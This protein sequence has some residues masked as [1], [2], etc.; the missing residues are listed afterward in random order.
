MQIKGKGLMVTYWLLGE[1]MYKMETNK[2]AGDQFTGHCGRSTKR[3]LHALECLVFN[4]SCNLFRFKRK[5]FVS[6]RGEFRHMSRR[7]KGRQRVRTAQ[8]ELD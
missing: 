6:A 7:E 4:Q 2:E 3:Y 1:D 5:S 8:A